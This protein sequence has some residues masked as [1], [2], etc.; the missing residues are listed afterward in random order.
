[1]KTLKQKQHYI[2]I[3]ILKDLENKLKL[4]IFGQDHAIKSIVNRLMIHHCGLNTPHK[5]IA[6]FLFTGPTGVG[7][8]ELAKSLAKTIGFNFS[9]FDMSEYVSKRSADTL[10]GGAAGLVGYEEG[11]LLTNAILDYPKSVVLFDEI[12]KAHPE[13]LN[14]FLQILDYATLTNTKGEKVDFTS[15]IIIMTSNLGSKKR[16]SR[17]MGFKSKEVVEVENNVSEFLTPELRARIQEDIEFNPLSQEM[18]ID[19]TKKYL[20]TIALQLNQ[21]GV[22]ITF[23][24]NSIN[25]LIKISNNNQLGAREVHKTIDNNL[26]ILI[27][28]ELIF[29]NISKNTTLLVDY[30][31]CFFIE[32]QKSQSQPI[33]NDDYDFLTAN[34]AQEYAKANIG[35]IIIR[36]PSGIGYI[37]KK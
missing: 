18:I 2:N 28:N 19:I 12:E 3:S 17:T 4:E 8:T 10:I 1:M 7:K 20:N 32:C 30:K 37:V 5:P 24:E 33:L 36:S 9:R 25:E 6:S 26:K 34:Q 14:L 35:T 23:S 29:G 13:V 27:S 31:D 21:S 16:K 22:R 15:T 11:G